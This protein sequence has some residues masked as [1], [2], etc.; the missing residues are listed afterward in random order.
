ML[1]KLLF[2]LLALVVIL[3]AL[4]FVLPQRYEVSRAALIRAPSSAVF[5]LIADLKQWPEWEPFSAGD[6]TTVTTLGERTTGV[7]ASQSW[8][9]QGNRGRLAFTGCD[10]AKG[11]DYDVVFTN[12]E[13]ESPAQ[14]WMHLAPGADGA[15]EVRWGMRGEMNMPVIGG[16]VALFA[17]RRIGA[18]FERGLAR[19]KAAAEQRAAA[20]K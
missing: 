2:A 4:G 5:P 3:L 15:V 1:K 12:G 14:S 6:P 18:L 11:I 19:L 16:Y 8:V 10:A 17:D 20:A 7:G 13:H 9:G